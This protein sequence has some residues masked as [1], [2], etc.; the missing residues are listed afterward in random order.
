MAGPGLGGILVPVPRP[1]G[2]GGGKGADMH[3]FDA[4]WLAR[5]H[6][7]E[8]HREAERARLAE[9]VRLTRQMDERSTSEPRP[10]A[11]LRL[12]RLGTW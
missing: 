5:Q 1:D 10:R 6:E 8:L 7:A 9:Q 4:L 11:R 3:P 12:R 2:P